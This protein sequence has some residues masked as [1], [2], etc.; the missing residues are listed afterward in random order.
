A[1]NHKARNLK[2]RN[3]TRNLKARNL[4]A[5]NL[6]ARNL[7]ARNL[8]ARNL[9][10]RNFKARNL[11][12]C[13]LKSRTSRHAT[14]SPFR[15][16]SLSSTKF[17]SVS[18][19][20]IFRRRI[21]FEEFTQR[22]EEYDALKIKY[23][24]INEILG[25]SS[26]GKPQEASANSLANNSGILHE[27]VVDQN[28]LGHALPIGPGLIN[29]KNTCYLNSVLQ[30]LA[31]TPPL[32]NVLM[33]GEHGKA[34]KWTVFYT[35]HR[36]ISLGM[37]LE[38]HV[39]RIFSGKSGAAFYPDNIV[40]NLNRKQHFLA[41]FKYGSERVE[42]LPSEEDAHEFM[43][44]L[45]D[46]AAKKPDVIH[47]IFGGALRSQVKCIECRR[48]SNK[49]DSILDLSLDVANVGSIGEALTEYTR[50][51]FLIE[52]N[53][54]RCEGWVVSECLSM[55]DARKQMTIHHAPMV[56]A[57]HL[58]RFQFGGYSQFGMDGEKIDKHIEFSE[59]LD[60]HEHVSPGQ[61]SDIGLYRL[62]AVL[63][64]VGASCTSGHYHCFIKGSDSEWYSMNDTSVKPVSLTTVL[65]Q[66]AY[67]LF[68]A[69]ESRGQVVVA[70][71]QG[72][73]RNLES[74]TDSDSETNGSA[75][76]HAKIEP[77]KVGEVAKRYSSAPSVI[78]RRGRTA[79]T[80][81][82]VVA[83]E[84]GRMR[85]TSPADAG[86]DR[87]HATSKSPVVAVNNE[88]MRATTKSAMVDAN[89]EKDQKPAKPPVCAGNN[90]R[91][92]AT[93]K[94]E[95]QKP[96]K[97]PLYRATTKSATVDTSE[98]DDQKPARSPL[99]ARNNKSSRATT[100]SATVDTSEEDDQKPA[101]SPLYARNNKRSRAT[102]KSATVDTSVEE[103]QKPAKS[104]LY[105]RNKMSRATTKSATVDTSE[106]DDQKPAMSPVYT[107]NKGDQAPT[108]SRVVAENR[109]RGQTPTLSPVIR[110]PI[111]TE[112][113][114][115]D[116]TSTTISRAN[117]FNSLL[118]T[119]SLPPSIDDAYAIQAP[120][121]VGSDRLAVM[122]LDL[123]RQ[124][125]REPVTTTYSSVLD[126][127]NR[128]TVKRKREEELEPSF[129]EDL[130]N[131]SGEAKA[132][133][134]EKG[135]VEIVVNYNDKKESKR[136]K[137]KSEAECE[138]SLVEKDTKLEVGLPKGQAAVFV[139]TLPLPTKI[140][141]R[142]VTSNLRVQEAPVT[143]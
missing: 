45:L 54:Y 67:M 16:S 22:D 143:I 88:R 103:D 97:S 72:V 80:W 43:R 94:S 8:K 129:I 92:P 10:A 34:C 50:P 86:Q 119:H 29:R 107:G 85:T 110:K 75:P 64:H 137:V 124:P 42:K 35:L 11:K 13:N 89:K 70:Q 56:L 139:N 132:N 37:E 61:E 135:N 58:K 62:Y 106:E 36:Q 47:Q 27:D 23:R 77:G 44:H 32:A 46:A 93:T 33:S 109:D 104:P 128:R 6:K 140:R 48:E 39:A 60:L 113:D 51:E 121:A 19:M 81:S 71:P 14:I 24:P 41:C 9:K 28:R 15:S 53:Q 49:F 78:Y 99:Y 40:R 131:V 138:E 111:V 87:C 101:K 52:D 59:T 83:M 25:T 73:K 74:I 118:L 105:A 65:R 100:K 115:K 84:R 134:V 82:E 79:A 95:D 98:E 7:K 31:Y 2:A 1:R 123:S 21:I 57:V 55:V 66:R 127:E 133:I 63:V 125:L 4:K 117:D 68:Y 38:G 96:A 114:C 126:N 116:T 30:C 102:T 17:P 12:A 141:Q 136:V 130:R 142:R 20:D 18:H 108:K 91:S 122:S 26:D 76:K 5:R 120:T 112:A 69:Q 3:L 90:E